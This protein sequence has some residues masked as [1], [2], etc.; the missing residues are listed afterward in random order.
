MCFIV[1]F[2]LGGNPKHAE[3]PESA[4]FFYI[5]RF[6]MISVET[7]RGILLCP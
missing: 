3:N 2:F 4:V 6:V 1:L 7:G 5:G